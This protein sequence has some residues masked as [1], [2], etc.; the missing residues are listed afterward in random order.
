MSVK[1]ITHATAR[2][3]HV[4][5]ACVVCKAERGQYLKAAGAPAPANDIEP[6]SR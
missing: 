6:K 2:L 4:I 5:H 1:T 3:R